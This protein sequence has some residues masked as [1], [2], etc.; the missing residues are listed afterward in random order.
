MKALEV[1][2]L[3][4]GVGAYVA[5]FVLPEKKE[6]NEPEKFSEEEVKKLLE[7]EG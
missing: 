2:L 1:L 6:K 7:K 5:S 4:M 3:I